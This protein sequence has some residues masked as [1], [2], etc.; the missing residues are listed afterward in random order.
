MFPMRCDLPAAPAPS[1]EGTGPGVKKIRRKNT[2][3]LRVGAK[4]QGQFL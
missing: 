4:I 2:D 3:A 1:L